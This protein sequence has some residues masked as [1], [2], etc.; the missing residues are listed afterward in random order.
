MKKNYTAVEMIV[1]LPGCEDILTASG[2]I[3]MSLYDLNSEDQAS[4]DELFR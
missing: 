4:F 3:S 2:G 1:I